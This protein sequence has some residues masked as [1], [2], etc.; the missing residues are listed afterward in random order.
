MTRTDA[1]TAILF[2]GLVIVGIFNAF[3]GQIDQATYLTCVAIAARL[4]G[5]AQ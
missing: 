3:Q 1:V 5:D 4:M 2:N